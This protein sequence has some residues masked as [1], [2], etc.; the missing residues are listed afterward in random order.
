MTDIEMN[1]V[2]I[3]DAE[4]ET[5]TTVKIADDVVAVIASLAAG[6]VEGV[7]SM[8]GSAVGGFVERLGIKNAS[9]G[10]RVE[11][12]ENECALALNINVVYGYKIQEVS[13]KIQENVKNAVE[14]MT[15]LFV[16]EVSIFV[17][18]I[19]FPQTEEVLVPDDEEEEYEDEQV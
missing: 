6:E 7:A 2:T 14:S 11:L 8:G 18:G 5:Q 17:Q 1:D 19:T 13:E 9:K 3:E 16:R 12:S 10:I 15:G 4:S